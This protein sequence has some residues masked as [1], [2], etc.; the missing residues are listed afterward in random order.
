M[1]TYSK[2]GWD[3]DVVY[4]GGAGALWPHCSRGT[5]DD[6]GTHLGSWFQYSLVWIQAKPKHLWRHD[7]HWKTAHRK[8]QHV[9]MD[10]WRRHSQLLGSC[11]L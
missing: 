8:R 6:P 7:V 2:E 4:C 5:P 3:K 1:V 9:P 11:I 10:H